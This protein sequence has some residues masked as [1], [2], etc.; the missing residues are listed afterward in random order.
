MSMAEFDEAMYRLTV[1]QRDDAWREIEHL[2]QV[3]ANERRATEDM[4]RR[5]MALIANVANH[6]AMFANPPVMIVNKGDLPTGT[7]VA[8]SE[9]G[10]L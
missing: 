8:M 2:K 1:M 10:K 7:R 5:Y 3:L 4:H 9:V 6:A